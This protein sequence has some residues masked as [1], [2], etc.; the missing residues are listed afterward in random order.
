VLSDP[1]VQRGAMVASETA[2]R[3]LEGGRGGRGGD[4]KNALKVDRRKA[5]KSLHSLFTRVKGSR[6]LRG[7]KKSEVM[8]SKKE[9]IGGLLL[10]HADV[11]LRRACS[12]YCR[13]V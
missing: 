11:K 3:G 4:E 6:G 2:V 10:Q 12:R 8:E 5:E 13:W 7:N 1:S 9:G